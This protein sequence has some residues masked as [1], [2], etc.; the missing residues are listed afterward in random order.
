M[1]NSIDNNLTVLLTI[2]DRQQF[3]F[4][5]LKYANNTSYPFKVLIADGG[6]DSTVSERLSDSRNFPNIN[7]EYFTY[8]YD[9]TDREYF[10]KI[11]D[12]I[13]KVKTS[14][15]VFVDDDD[16]NFL[17]QVYIYEVKNSIILNR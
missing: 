6:K 16:F 3:T 8:P 4:R 2:K 14:Y 9:Q 17:K 15:V 5:W 12:L 7:Y 13:S 10:S 1:E 11:M